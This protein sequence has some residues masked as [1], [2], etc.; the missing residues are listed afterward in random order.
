MDKKNALQC[1]WKDCDK[2]GDYELEDKNGGVWAF[3][4]QGHY[5]EYENDVGIAI[6]DPS[7]HNLK[8]MLSGYV[9][10]QGGAKELVKKI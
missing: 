8:K 2:E 6:Q 10:A 5:D 1:T 3:L 4:C 7:K 9:K